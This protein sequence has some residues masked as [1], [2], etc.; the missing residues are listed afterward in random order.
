MAH[1]VR[2][3]YLNGPH[4]L[5]RSDLS[6]YETHAKTRGRFMRGATAVQQ[7]VRTQYGIDIRFLWVKPHE[8]PYVP[9][10]VGR[11]ETYLGGGY[12]GTMVTRNSR[13]IWAT[14]FIGH[15]PFAV[16]L[17][18]GRLLFH[19]LCHLWRLKLGGDKYGHARD[20]RDQFHAD[21]GPLWTESLNPVMRKCGKIKGWK[22]P[23]Q[24]QLVADIRLGC[25]RKGVRL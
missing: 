7:H 3:C 20:R 9:V 2:I 4:T 5:L 23:Q 19:E 6:G 1:V 10:S 13:E 12:Y 11:K 25:T 8:K 18:F 16:P 17:T 22:P 15:D 24:L 14:S 21:C